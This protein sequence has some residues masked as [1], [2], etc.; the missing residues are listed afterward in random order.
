[1]NIFINTTILSQGKPFYLLYLN[2]LKITMPTW[3]MMGKKKPRII[4]FNLNT[5]RNL[6]RF[7]EHKLKDEYKKLVQKECLYKIWWPVMLIL[8]YYNWTKR[9]S[10]LENNCI[11]HV[12]YFLDALVELWI[13]P[14]DDYDTVKQI[15]FLYGGYDKNNARVEIRVSEYSD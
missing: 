5:Y 10:D 15:N 1:M 12:K 14:T 9:K 11:I 4:S 7:L 6:D 13:I 2:M 8:T 3:I